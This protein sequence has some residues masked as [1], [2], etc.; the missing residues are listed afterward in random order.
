MNSFAQYQRESRRLLLEEAT[1]AARRR[2]AEIRAE[3]TAD[4]RQRLAR[5]TTEVAPP[6]TTPS[7]G[8]RIDP[9]GRVRLICWEVGQVVVRPARKVTQ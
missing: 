1:A 2:L 5:L 6:S 7:V 4:R 3:Q 8:L 9:Q